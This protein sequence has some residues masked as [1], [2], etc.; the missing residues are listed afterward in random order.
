MSEKILYYKALA[1]LSVSCCLSPDKE[2]QEY[3]RQ[4]LQKGSVLWR[5]GLDT[6]I[7][8]KNSILYLIDPSQ[9]KF[10]EAINEN[11]KG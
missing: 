8:D 4:T 6:Y 7:D 10:M 5:A 9:R 3:I 1:D 11:N 2:P